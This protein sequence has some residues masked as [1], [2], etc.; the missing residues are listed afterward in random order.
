MSKSLGNVLD[1]RDIIA[2]VGLQVLQEKLR[3]GNLDPEELAIAAATQRKDFPHGIPECGTD[4]LR[5]TLCSHGALGGDLHLSVSEVLSSRHF[6]NKIWNALRF[7]LSV[8]G[9]GFVPQ[10]SEE[11]REER[12]LG[13]GSG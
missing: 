5:F 9:R 13:G 10:P 1:P 6:C 2:G 11:V 8:L 4:A 7:I 3:E 12:C